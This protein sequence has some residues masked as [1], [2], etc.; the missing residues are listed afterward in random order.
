M[1]YRVFLSAL[2]A[3]LI[4]L[5]AYAIP[6]KP[7]AFN[8]TQP[9]G[10]IIRLELHG[11]E[12]FSWTTLA[13]TSQ[14]VEL[15]ANG[16]WRPTTI[17]PGQRQEAL[18]RRNQVNSQRISRRSHANDLMT[19]GERHI[20][21][22][23]VAFQDQDFSIDNPQEQFIALLN[24]SG[25][26][27]NGGT[28]SVQDFYLENS[29][30]QFKPIFDVYGPVTLQ[31]EMKYYGEPVRNSQGKIIE[32][33]IQPELALYEA[34][35]LLDDSIDFSQ[36]DVNNDGYVDMTLFYFAGYN[37]AEGAHQNTI[38]PH[39]WNLQG[40]SSAEARNAR[41]DGK[42][43]NRYFC[44]SELRGNE[45]VNMCG[46][47]TTCHEF[48]HSLGLPDFYDTDYEDN[49]YAGGLYGFSTMDSGSYNNNG[50]TPPYFNAE[51]RIMLGWMEEED[52]KVLPPGATVIPSITGNVA[53]MS[54][55]DTSG[56][57]FI[58]EY[59]DKTG[60]DRPLPEGLLV[61]HADKSTTRSVGGISP[62]DHWDHW[63]WYNKINAYG[64]HP[65][66]YIVP[67]DDQKNLA[68]SGKGRNMVFPGDKNITTFT[69]IDW[70]ESFT[71]LTLNNITLFPG[72]GVSVNANYSDERIIM[73]LV[74]TQNGVGIP[75]VR[76][77]VRK[78]NPAENA[79]LRP[80]QK[81]SAP[82]TEYECITANDGTFQ[83][84]MES[85]DSPDARITF[86]KDGYQTLSRDFTVK[87]LNRVQEVLFRLGEE[88]A[89]T[90]RYYDEDEDAYYGGYPPLGNSQ[91]ASIRIPADELPESGGI[92]TS[93][94]FYP[95][96]PAD[97]YYV[98]IDSG[99]ERL[100]TYKVPGLEEGADEPILV[101]LPSRVFPAGKDLYVGY[102]VENAQVEY[103]GYPI[104]I[105]PGGNHCYYSS[106]NLEQSN[107]EYQE[108]EGFDLFLAAD[109]AAQ[110]SEADDMIHTFSQMGIN[111]IN[112]PKNGTYA[113]G[114][115]FLLGVDCFEG[116][117]PESVSWF[118]DGKAQNGNSVVLTD[119]K[120]TITA[121]LKYADGSVETLEL[122]IDVK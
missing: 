8:Y 33:D 97:A 36:Y 121:A 119:G 21:V 99:E 100:L 2:A 62:Y 72:E 116:S 54:K 78:S 25:Y 12:F 107:W 23:L 88:V 29:H 111:A 59:R 67:A 46:I 28:G 105:I 13:G 49:G 27:E 91:M 83:I 63:S 48:G 73:G 94:M 45:G 9:D 95:V 96:C 85:F 61:Y 71:G 118:M 60:W 34:A 106:L 93:V 32:N 42:A 89:N 38:W 87:R 110:T 74:Q 66:F 40:S 53:Y 69:P 108:N 1:N 14:A 79:S 115:N 51:E 10:S 26:S 50:R 7:G 103:E 92:V 15:D 43:L 77:T 55:T 76:V 112:D 75:G 65:C 35:L 30:G 122:S 47:G 84:K 68:Y 104:I 52:L 20:P 18:R 113:V 64:D 4:S 56:E 86:S 109:I 44:T 39:Q 31:H 22:L 70:E 17:T 81:K 6:A 57:Y 101:D 82:E 3:S 117:H 37:Q 80:R 11:D 120:H 102:A 19:H 90:Y 24:Q 98:I 5:A 114:D 41:F 58:Y 16:Y